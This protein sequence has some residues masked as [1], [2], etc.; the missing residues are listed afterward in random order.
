LIT[1]SGFPLSANV[2]DRYPASATAV[3]TALLS[4]LPPARVAELYWD[5][6]ELVAFTERSTTTLTQLQAKL[7]R[8]REQGYALD[9]G[10]VHPS[11]VG[12]WVSCPVHGSCRPDLGRRGRRPHSALRAAIR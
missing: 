4:E 1:A 2:G 5:P 6:R 11:V 7:E 12:P 8:T 3:G 9:D 10:E